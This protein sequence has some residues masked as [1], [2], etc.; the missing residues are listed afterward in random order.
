MKEF[1]QW[2]DAE[3]K[4]LF[5]CIE[6]IKKANR[7]LLCGFREFARKY[8]RKANSVR[9]YYY[10]EVENLKKDKERRKRLNI[11]LSIHDIQRP[12]KFCNNETEKLVTEI[13]RLKCLGFS[14]RRACL[15]LANNSPEIMLRYQNKFRSVMKDNRSLYNKCLLNLRKNGLSES[16]EKQKE[17]NN[18]I[19]MK[20]PEERKLTDED[21]NS[22]FLGLVKLVKKNAIDNIEKDLSSE[23]EFANMALRETLMKVANLEKEID[24]KKQELNKEQEKN[25]QILEENFMLKT[26]LAN[27]I[28]EKLRKNVKNKSLTKYLRDIKDKGLQIKTKI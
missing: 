21:V 19:Y 9:N 3:V 14:I 16:K 23:T 10:L 25:K 22:L 26:K 2:K 18:I 7:S 27:L 8:K 6:K 20:K 13:L 5:D 28:S 15:K 12:S 11:D 17:H 1:S 4:G 24:N